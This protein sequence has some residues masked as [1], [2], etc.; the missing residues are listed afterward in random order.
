[1][2]RRGQL[3]MQ[4]VERADGASDDGCGDVQIHSG[5]CQLGVAEQQLNGA[6]FGA[7]FEQM[8]AKLWRKVCRLTGLFR[9]AERRAARQAICSRLVLIG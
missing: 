9:P 8:V 3:E 6:D 2:I 7:G 1:M 5:R 4:L